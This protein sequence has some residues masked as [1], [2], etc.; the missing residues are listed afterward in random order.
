[1]A[2]LSSCGRDSKAKIID[3][4]PKEASKVDL[5]VKKPPASVGFDPRVGKIP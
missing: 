2:E 4:L 3:C 5:V 1:M